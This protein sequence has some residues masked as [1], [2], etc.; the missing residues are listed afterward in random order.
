MSACKN[1][2]DV[3]LSW[4]MAGLLIALGSCVFCEISTNSVGLSLRC[5]IVPEFVHLTRGG[6][7]YS[8]IC[9]SNSGYPSTADLCIRL[10]V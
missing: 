6:D 4:E 7:E 1:V 8:R 10:E 3:L 9:V 5:E 2:Y